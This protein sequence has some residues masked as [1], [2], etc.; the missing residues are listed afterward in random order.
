MKGE[1]E[2]AI[3]TFYSCSGR[4]SLRAVCSPLRSVNLKLS[5]QPFLRRLLLSEGGG[6]EE[7]VLG[8][9][10]D[11]T[12]EKPQLPFFHLKEEGALNIWKG[13]NAP[14]W[15]PKCMFLDLNGNLVQ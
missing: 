14:F 6:E 4:A 11:D 1:R 3:W 7:E 13:R 9:R 10:A 2:R 5:L 12:Q 15:Q 8:R